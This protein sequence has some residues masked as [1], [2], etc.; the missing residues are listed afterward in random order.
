MNTYEENSKFL[1]LFIATLTYRRKSISKNCPANNTRDKNTVQPHYGAGKEYMA[2]QW[3][4][5]TIV[6]LGISKINMKQVYHN[7]IRLER[8]SYT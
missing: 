2:C 7:I 8:N 6:G 3:Y 1:I 5:A 4:C